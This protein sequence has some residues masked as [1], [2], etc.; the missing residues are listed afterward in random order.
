MLLC[1]LTGWLRGDWVINTSSPKQWS[2]FAPCKKNPPLFDHI[3][4][5]EELFI[6]HVPVQWLG[7]IGVH[8]IKVL[9]YSMVWEGRG[10]I[11]VLWSSLNF[12]LS[13]SESHLPLTPMPSY[14]QSIIN[15]PYGM[16]CRIIIKWHGFICLIDTMVSYVCW[17][18]GQSRAN[19]LSL[20][21]F[22]MFSY[23]SQKSAEKLFS[24]KYVQ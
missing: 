24:Q 16:I 8:E 2:C 13:R 10:W 12:L 22:Y 1:A 7:Y 23:W 11:W 14:F 5:G 9:L 21:K 4:F 6:I 3:F 15:T 20:S 17:K 18:R 19:F